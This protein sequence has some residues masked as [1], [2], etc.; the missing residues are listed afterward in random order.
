MLKVVFRFVCWLNMYVVV[1]N[2][3]NIKG[4][5]LVFFF[6]NIVVGMCYCVFLSMIRV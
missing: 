3:N 4:K 1:E 2:K 5:M 6:Y